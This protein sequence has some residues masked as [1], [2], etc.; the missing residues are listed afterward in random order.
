VKQGVEAWDHWRRSNMTVVPNLS[1][2]D[3]SRMIL[4]RGN[5]SYA[6]FP[7]VM[8]AMGLLTEAHRSGSG[9]RHKEASEMCHALPIQRMESDA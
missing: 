3:L 6:P 1:G 5:F 8:A 7:P 2:A 9:A 4:W